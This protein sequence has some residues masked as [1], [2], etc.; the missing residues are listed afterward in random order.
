MQSAAG[1]G[2]ISNVAVR[3][4]FILGSGMRLTVPLAGVSSADS[5]VGLT[6]AT[7]RRPSVQS[8]PAALDPAAA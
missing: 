8:A 5:K 4:K 3:N 1:N 6:M 7:W 2:F